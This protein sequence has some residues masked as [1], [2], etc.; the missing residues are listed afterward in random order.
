MHGMETRKYFKI[1]E[2]AQNRAPNTGSSRT[3]ALPLE[4]GAAC[5]KWH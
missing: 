1:N 5:Q 4:T 2:A 3:A